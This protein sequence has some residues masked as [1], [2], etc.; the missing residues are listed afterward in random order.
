MDYIK[1]LERIIKEE[2]DTLLEEDNAPVSRGYSTSRKPGD[3][4][5]T[6]SG[7]WGATNKDAKIDYFDNQDDAKAY[8]GKTQSYVDR[9]AAA[10][11]TKPYQFP[12]SRP[13]E[14]PETRAN[15]KA[16]EK[17]NP[18]YMKQFYASQNKPTNKI[19]QHYTPKQADQLDR[20]TK[21]FENLPDKNTQMDYERIARVVYDT[22][23][24]KG[25][26]FDQSLQYI[27]NR[28]QRATNSKDKR[29]LGMTLGWLWGE[30]GGYTGEKS[31][32]T[33]LTDPKNQ[34]SQK[35]PDDTKAPDLSANDD[36]KYDDRDP[37][38]DG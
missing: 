14:N 28:A 36:Y 15:R 7:N 3:V 33:R 22:L 8:A 35:I 10:A 6:A 24:Q 34:G 16:A 5:Q 11:T 19:R 21:E 29:T 9:T 20:L 32:N 27:A 26:D 38:F 23:N 12:D 17:E 13:G 30:F 31:W 1:G 37:E 18:E 2:L 25:F 4:W